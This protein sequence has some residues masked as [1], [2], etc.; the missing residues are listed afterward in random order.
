MVTFCAPEEEDLSTFLLN[1]GWEFQ[2]PDDPYSVVKREYEQVYWKFETYVIMHKLSAEYYY[3]RAFWFNF[4]PLLVVTTAVSICG[5]LATSIVDD[6][7]DGNLTIAQFNETWMI[8]ESD[9]VVPTITKESLPVIVAL[10]GL[11]ATF[12]ASIGKY[13][14]YQSKGDMHTSS[15][16]TLSEICEALDFDLFDLFQ[17]K[18]SRQPGLEGVSTKDDDS[19]KSTISVSKENNADETKLNEL[20]MDLKTHKAKFDIVERACTVPIPNPME[21]AFKNLEEIFQLVPFAVRRKLYR[22]YYNELWHAFTNQRC[23]FCC[24]PIMFPCW[25]PSINV[26]RVFDAKLKAECKA[27]L[28]RFSKRYGATTS[29]SAEW[30]NGTKNSYRTQ[31]DVEEAHVGYAGS[32]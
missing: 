9:L 14:N 10:L 25:A 21:Q 24:L 6:L 5:F 18:I 26:Q 7:A 12:I 13:L 27:L 4:I 11:L 29:A 15:V 28:S 1:N 8:P 16:R 19:R 20:L 30:D 32:V 31:E 2:E 23:W 22:R 17:Q 3:F